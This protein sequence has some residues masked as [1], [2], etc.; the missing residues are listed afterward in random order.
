[1]GGVLVI[2]SLNYDV[3]IHVQ[4]IPSVGETV[5]GDSISYSCGGKGANQAYASGKA[6][7]ETT[8]LGAV[9]DDQYGRI[10]KA[11]L[12]NAGVHTDRII[13]ME[14]QVSGMSFLTVDRK[15][16]NNIV[17]VPG[18]NKYLTREH[19]IANRSLFEKNSISLL[20]L[21][22]PV[23]TVYEAIDLSKKNNVRV[24]LNP[25]PCRKIES[26]YLKL[27]DILTPNEIELSSLVPEYATIEEKAFHLI[28]L[29]VKNVIVTLGK[30]GA[31]LVNKKKEA[32]YFVA[33]AVKVLNTVGAGDC[34]NGYL[35]GLI[36]E[37]YE[38]EGAISHA[39]IAS[40][41]SV[42]RAG[43][44]ESIPDIEEMWSFPEK[45]RRE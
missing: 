5:L 40:S 18:A 23:E 41:I 1:M 45:L 29:G 26:R 17:N 30:K 15:G 16:Q 44:Q 12:K 20:Q 3:L 21:E 11:N 32:K 28:D 8:M 34:F 14:N 38:I 9:G 13:T 35:A 25:A 39:V 33:P 24:I 6:R 31:L 43:T 37:N 27:I 36:S 10:L 19:I 7:V 4:K 2:G 22:I 42:M